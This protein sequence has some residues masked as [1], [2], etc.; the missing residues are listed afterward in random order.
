MFLLGNTRVLSIDY[1]FDDCGFG[2]RC[3]NENEIWREMGKTQKVAV[4]LE[5]HR[6]LAVPPHW[7]TIAKDP[8]GWEVERQRLLA[9]WSVDGFS[10]AR[11]AND[12]AMPVK[13]AFAMAANQSAE[14]LKGIRP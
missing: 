7:L 11:A 1:K 6:F 12:F 5:D 14:S 4:I 10:G 13:I 2:C 9:Q 8:P 3:C